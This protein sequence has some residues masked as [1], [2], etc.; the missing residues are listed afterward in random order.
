MKHDAPHATAGQTVTLRDD[1]KGTAA[2]PQPGTQFR[3]EDYWDRITGGS[4]MDAEGNPAALKY[5]MRSG[6][7]AHLP[8]DDEVVY[9]KDEN[10][11]GHLVHVS[12]IKS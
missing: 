9:G 8:L 6:L 3:V 2:D 11:Y 1:F 7:E 4:W 10:G 12:E 5:A